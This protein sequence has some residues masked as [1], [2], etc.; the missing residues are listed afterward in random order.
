M[1]GNEWQIFKEYMTGIHIESM[2][3]L[4]IRIHTFDM[5]T[6]VTYVKTINHIHVT[7]SERS[8]KIS[9]NLC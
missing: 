9:N 1:E 4:Y 5:I 8:G 2:Y 3:D 6:D 7:L